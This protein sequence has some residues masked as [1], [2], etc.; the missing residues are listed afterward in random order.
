MSAVVDGLAVTLYLAV[1]ARCV[2]LS[3]TELD[4]AGRREV[5]RYA[6]AAVAGALWPASLGTIL[7]WA[8]VDRLRT[9]GRGRS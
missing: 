7:A 6:G 5:W 2:S 8:A 9:Q 3:F 1:A 4:A